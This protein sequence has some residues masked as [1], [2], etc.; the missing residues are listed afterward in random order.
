VGPDYDTTEALRNLGQIIGQHQAHMIPR[1][2]PGEGNILVYDNGGR[3]GFGAPNP[4]APT[5]LGYVRRDYSR[6]VEFD[7]MTLEIV[8]QH[9]PVEAGFVVYG[10][11]AQFYSPSISGM[12]R[13]PNGNTLICEGQSGRL[14]EVT[15]EH[16]TVWEYVA[17]TNDNPA[18]GSD[19]IN[20]ISRGYR[21][22]YGWVPQLD[23]PEEMAIP[24]VDSARFRVPGSPEEKVG[25]ITEVRFVAR[26]AGFEP[27]T[28]GSE[29]VG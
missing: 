28:L 9:G 25:R 29:D 3:A 7:P 1:G 8:W 15:R 14:I 12:Q 27:A 23:P 20:T 26:P 6:V 19:S 4:G 16:E 13:L 5:G 11:A 21:V 17:P 22:P 2:L 24:R 10:Q 18:P